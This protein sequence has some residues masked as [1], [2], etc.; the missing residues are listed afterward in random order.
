MAVIGLLAF[1]LFAKLFGYWVGVGAQL[2]VLVSGQLPRFALNATTDIFFLLLCLAALVIFIS[3]GLAVRSR[4]ALAAAITSFAYLTRYN[5]LFL[6]AACLF[7]MI[8]LNLFNGAWRERLKLAALFVV[9]FLVTA[10]PWLYLNYR[11]HGS[12]F[13]NTNYLNMATLFYG[14]LVGGNVY[15]EGTRALEEVFHSF[16][17]MLR[18]DPKRIMTHYPV[19]LYESLKQS[20]TANLVSP[21]SGWLAVAGCLLVLIERRSK[22]AL[23]L[24][25]AGALY[26]L[27][28]ALNHWEARYYFFIAVI[29]AGLAVYAIIRPLELLRAR[30]WLNARA[31]ALIPA[32]II[33]TMWFTSFASAR[34]DVAR[35]LT[36]HPAEVPAAC[37]YFKR[38]GV[39]GAR[40]LSR[41]PHVPY[42]A[43]QEWAFFPVVKSPDEF[44]AWLKDN[45]VDYIIFSSVE[46]SRRRAL[47]SLKDPQSAPPWLKAVWTN[48][49]PPFVI[50]KPSLEH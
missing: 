5:A 17:E 15:Q 8:A 42:L 50:Y 48:Q 18:Y 25:L 36:E 39:S 49:N 2:M 28:M 29:Y 43:R 3:D 47:A 26:F 19:N 14:N 27:L 9:V 24:L 38:E 10:S 46:L 16:G 7:G 23:L 33:L 41:K 11:H 12:P 31:F 44:K 21:W 34:Q 4:V 22:A 6:L 13:Y 40:V 32:A 30:G 35:F 37:D 45:P 20:L 1:L